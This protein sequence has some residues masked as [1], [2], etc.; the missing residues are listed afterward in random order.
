MTRQINVLPD[1]KIAD[2]ASAD[3][4][5]KFLEASCASV[6]AMKA[7]REALDSDDPEA[8][9]A[10]CV[11]YTVASQCLTEA[12]ESILQSANSATHA[13]SAFGMKGATV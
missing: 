8:I 13:A 4:S 1:V 5:L 3:A 11:A 9:A 2:K 12:A 10:A 6:D 7:G